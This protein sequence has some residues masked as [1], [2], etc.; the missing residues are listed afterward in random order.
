MKLQHNPEFVPREAFGTRLV[1]RNSNNVSLSAEARGERGNAGDASRPIWMG[2]RRIHG[3]AR[4]HCPALPG[5][6]GC[7]NWA[8]RRKR[9]GGERLEALSKSLCWCGLGYQC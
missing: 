8:V 2:C 1:G 9:L 7:S 5:T 3:H 6:G 4:G